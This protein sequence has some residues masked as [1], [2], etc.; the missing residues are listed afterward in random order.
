MVTTKAPPPNNLP[1]HKAAMRR[2]VLAARAQLTAAQRDHAATALATTVTALARQ[3]FDPT[4]AHPHPPQVAAYVSFG[5]EPPTGPLLD[6]LTDAGYD[7]VVPRVQPGQQL[8]W[9]LYADRDQ[10][11]ANR[12]GILEPPA[13]A[14]S[15]ALAASQLIVIPGLAADAAGARLGRGGGFYDRALADRAR[16]AVVAVVVYPS[17]LLPHVPA[18]AHDQ[19]VDAVITPHQVHWVSDGHNPA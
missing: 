1:A 2:Q 19:R 8:S 3:L 4:P 17:E 5:N 15:R 9:H 16:T 10:L 6:Q 7:A 11:H 12:W 14:P 13:H 18:E